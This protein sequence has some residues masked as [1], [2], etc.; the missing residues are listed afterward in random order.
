MVGGGLGLALLS[1]L[2]VAGD[3]AKFTAGFFRLGVVPDC[4]TLFTLPRL[5]GLAKARN[6][7]F[8]NGT[9]DA[10]MAVELGI[11]LKTV[12]DA[13]VDAEGLALAHSL[14][15]GP[16]EV[17]GIAKLLL[18]K[19]FESSMAEMWDGERLNQILA[20]SS[21]EFH[22]GLNAL[23]EKRAPDFIAASKSGTMFDGMPSSATDT[24]PK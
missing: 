15:S 5:V 7:I 9:W 22:E 23:I 18:L 20:M 24:P 1:D 4:L 10:S 14:A 8:S 11:A 13:E 3:S 6:F 21:A 19:S 12:P 16:A 17:M 2:I